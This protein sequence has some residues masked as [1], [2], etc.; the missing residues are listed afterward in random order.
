LTEIDIVLTSIATNESDRH[1]DEKCASMEKERGMT[2][3]PKHP[4]EPKWLFADLGML[5]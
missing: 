5:L 3:T 4:R 2:L 1:N